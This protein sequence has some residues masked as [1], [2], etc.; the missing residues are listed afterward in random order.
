M[1]QNN[2]NWER[3]YTLILRAGMNTN[4]F[5]RH[6]GLPCAE[7]LYRIKRGSNGISKDLAEK[8]AIKFPEISRAWILTGE[9]SMFRNDPSRKHSVPLYEGDAAEAVR[10]YELTAPS[11]FISLPSA[12]QC[13]L[14]VVYGRH[15]LSNIAADRTILLLKKI[16][17]KDV[18]AGHE[19]LFVSKNCLTLRKVRSIYRHSN[20]DEEERATPELPEAGDIDMVFAVKGR[21]TLNKQ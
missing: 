21:I 17:K 14:A 19:Y 10:N 8:I 13:D 2:D 1:M 20:G 6:I 9:G 7:N 11:G 4:S 16:D 12:G 15:A 18:I 5:A 3:I